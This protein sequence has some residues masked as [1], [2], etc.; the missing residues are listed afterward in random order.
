MTMQDR[1]TGGW[2]VLMGE[3]LPEVNG[4]RPSEENC[5]NDEEDWENTNGQNK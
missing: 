5:H 3:G 4:K 1:I 2:A